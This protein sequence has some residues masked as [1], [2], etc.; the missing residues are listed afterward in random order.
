[1][2]ISILSFIEIFE[3]LFDLF[4]LKMQQKLN[5]KKISDLTENDK[6]EITIQSN[7]FNPQTNWKSSFSEKVLPEKTFILEYS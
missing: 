5:K 1:L 3:L 2:G 6:E 7:D 4:H